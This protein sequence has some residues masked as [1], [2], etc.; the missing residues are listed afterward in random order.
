MPRETITRV[1]PTARIINTEYWRSMLMRLLT[2]RKS[3][4]TIAKATTSRKRMIRAPPRPP[5]AGTA[6]AS[7]PF[8]ILDMRSS[9][10][11]HYLLFRSAGLKLPDDA[12]ARHHEQPVPQLPRL[13][14]LR[15]HVEYR[16]PLVG[17]PAH[18]AE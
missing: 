4:V 5:A 18:E 6:L 17:Q 12:P 3:G 11:R 16:D 10:R 1:W 9:R 15:G 14:D 8:A 7:I 13:P 2:E